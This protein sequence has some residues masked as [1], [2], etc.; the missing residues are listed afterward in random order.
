MT[1]DIMNRSEITFVLGG[2]RSGKS[3]F[4]EQL[5]QEKSKERIY[6]AT[7]QAYDHE[8]KSRISIHQHRRDQTWRTVDCP[9]ELPKV[10]SELNMPDGA[11]LVDCL[12]LWT[13][14]IMLGERDIAA[15][16]AALITALKNASCPIILVA[17]EVG[18]GIVPDN[19]MGR[20]F[21][22][23]AGRVNQAVAAASDQVYFIAAGLPLK[24]KG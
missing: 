12:T 21:R 10:I 19:K 14:N 18:L 24:L 11:V 3:Q 4:A 16:T 23:H 22:D 17:N 15:D 2:A 5:C 9:I 7:A 20:D 13:T 1:Q 6:I 8:M